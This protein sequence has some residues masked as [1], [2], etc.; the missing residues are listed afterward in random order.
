MSTK[1]GIMIMKTEIGDKGKASVFLL[2]LSQQIEFLTTLK[3]GY[4]DHVL[5]E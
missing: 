1:V 3:N 5:A 4:I 2:M